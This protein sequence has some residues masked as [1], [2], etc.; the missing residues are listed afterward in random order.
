MEGAD[1]PP[2]GDREI[3]PSYPAWGGIGGAGGVVPLG[4]HTQ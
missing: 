1:T 3:S 2:P 4:I